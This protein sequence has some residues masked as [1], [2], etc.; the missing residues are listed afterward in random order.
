MQAVHIPWRLSA[1]SIDGWRMIRTDPDVTDSFGDSNFGPACI[2]VLVHLSREAERC[3]KSR[4]EGLGAAEECIG[5]S[6][7]LMTAG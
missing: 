6:D 1:V 2:K 4:G 7:E 5:A 3:P